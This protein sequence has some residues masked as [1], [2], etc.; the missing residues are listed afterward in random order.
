MGTKLMPWP[1]PSFLTSIGGR[2]LGAFAVMALL[3]C[4]LGTYGSFMLSMAGHVVADTYDRPLMAINFARAASLD[5]MRMN[6][7]L[8]R[9]KLLPDA[10]A[11]LE[12]HIDEL[13]KEFRADLAVAEQRSLSPKEIQVIEQIRG[14]AAQWNRARRSAATSTTDTSVDKLSEQT[15]DR[16]DTLTEL[17]ADHAFVERRIAIW[18]I[19]RFKYE[20]IAASAAALLIAAVIMWQLTRRIIR[21]LS[22]AARVADRIAGGELHTPIPAGGEDETGALLRSMTVMQDNI[23]ATVER[24]KAEKHSAQKRLIDALESASEGMILVD[25]T[26]R[27]VVANSQMPALFP[28]LAPYLFAGTDFAAFVRLA[29]AQIATPEGGAALERGGEIQ[30]SDGR[31]IRVSRSATDESGFFLLLSDFTDIKEREQRYKE[32]KLQAEAASN[33][34]SRFLANMGHEL[35]TPLN[36]IIGF[37]EI[38]SGQTFGPQAID[39]YAGYAASILGSGQHLLGVINAVLDL[40]R[41]ETGSLELSLEPVDLREILSSCARLT[42]EQCAQAGLGFELA[43]GDEPL[44]VNGDAAKLRQAFLNLL[45][46]AAK[47]TPVGGSAGLSAG[48]K[49]DMVWVE[50]FDTGIGMTPEDIPLA[51]TPFEQVDAKFARRYEGT[52]L[53]LPLAKALVELHGGTLAIASEPGKGTKVTVTLKRA[54]DE[55]PALQ[56]VSNR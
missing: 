17:T 55:R 6:K 30:L 48:T 8:L 16:F 51:F 9:E 43:I 4:A 39:K 28:S 12:R 11:Q 5:F 52:G 24:E 45:A 29:R 1:L 26:G 37:S 18:S 46:N 53:G 22:A 7:E 34:K 25:S 44:P 38:I 3:I 15:I 13:D 35:R 32:A 23:R 42:R 31:W 21:P 36:A 40:A 54:A 14:L 33:A 56:L 41:I 50:I 27:I 20:V 49:A 47:F 2:M 10:R 19:A